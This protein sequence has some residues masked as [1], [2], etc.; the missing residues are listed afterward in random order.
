MAARTP[1]RSSAELVGCGGPNGRRWRKGRSKRSTRKPAEQKASA[2]AIS[3]GAVQL[4]PAPWVM[5]RPG[6]VGLAGR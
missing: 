4:A 2:T 5:A 1:A 6:P 3:S